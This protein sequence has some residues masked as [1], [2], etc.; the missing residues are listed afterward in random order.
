MGV[1]RDEGER[2]KERW[3]GARAQAKADSTAAALAVGR[4]VQ[5]RMTRRRNVSGCQRKLV[6][7]LSAPRSVTSCWWN[8]VEAVQD[9]TERMRLSAAR[10]PAPSCR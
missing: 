9:S 4:Q 6:V 7:G 2:G 3:T 10:A 5:W 8:T 1:N